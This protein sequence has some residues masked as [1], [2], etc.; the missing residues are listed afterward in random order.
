MGDEKGAAGLF[1]SLKNLFKKQIPPSEDLAVEAELF[2]IF[3]QGALITYNYFLEVRVINRGGL[4]AAI[5]TIVCESND[6]KLFP[7]AEKIYIIDGKPN[8]S[9]ELAKKNDTLHENFPLE[10]SSAAQF[11]AAKP[12]VLVTTRSGKVFKGEIDRKNIEEI[13]AFQGERKWVITLEERKSR[14]I[15]AFREEWSK[16]NIPLEEGDI[17]SSERDKT[18]SIWVEQESGLDTS[19]DKFVIDLEDLGAG[20]DYLGV[21]RYRVKRWLL[22]YKNMETLKKSSGPAKWLAP[23]PTLAPILIADDDKDDCLLVTRALEANFV[24]NPVELVSN[25]EEL[26]DYLRR[27]GD[28]SGQVPAPCFILLDLRMPRMNGFEALEIIKKNE[29]FRKIPVVIFSSSHDEEDI[30]KSYD[31]GANS[32]IA[33][34]PTFGGMV[35]AMWRLQ[36]Y[37]FGTAKL[38]NLNDF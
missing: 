27:Q 13:K 10:I 37:W 4:P 23:L 1:G 35:E 17:R 24:E 31:R 28:F 32:Y 11:E 38:P 18:W 21:I 26:L 29:K 5:Q 16:H 8:Q 33:K 30:A 15:S 3:D 34:P 22:N 2:L 7:G 9:V 36:N 12:L 6:Q 19:G 20:V 25:G 14:I